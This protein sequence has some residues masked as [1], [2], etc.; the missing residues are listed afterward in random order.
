MILILVKIL[1]KLHAVTAS[2]D[3]SENTGFILSKEWPGD[4][5][6]QFNEKRY[7]SQRIRAGLA[8][9]GLAKSHCFYCLSYPKEPARAI[10]SQYFGELSYLANFSK[11]S[12]RNRVENWGS[13]LSEILMKIWGGR[14][15]QR[16]FSPKFSQRLRSWN[17]NCSTYPGCSG[18]HLLVVHPLVAL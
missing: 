10:L 15:W 18:G 11:I 3:K 16:G 8:Y 1:V 4:D 12:L 9:A 17:G 14:R 2:R 6:C 13:F 7:Q 5:R